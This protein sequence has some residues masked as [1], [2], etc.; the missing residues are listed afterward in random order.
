MIITDNH[1]T[2]R[3]VTDMNCL[4]APLTAYPITGFRHIRLYPDYSRFELTTDPEWFKHYMEKDYFNY[5]RL[6]RHPNCY[7]EGYFLWDAWGKENNYFQIVVKDAIAHFGST[8]RGLSILKKT[9]D[10]IDKYEFSTNGTNAFL[11]SHIET[12]EQFIQNYKEKSVKLINEMHQKKD[13]LP[14]LIDPHCEYDDTFLPTDILTAIPIHYTFTQRPKNIALTPR[15]LE[16]IYWL[17]AGKTIPDIAMILN[18]SKR[19]VE[20]FI[21]SL[22]EK[23]NARTLFQVGQT[24]TQLGLNYLIYRALYTH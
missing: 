8:G 13:S 18:R 3:L 22:K 12:F 24:A 9:P 17:I 11:M 4:C 23:L 20:K 2:I 21:A 14:Y 7:Q 19:T 5:S 15:E 1:P 10:W 6:D 16:C